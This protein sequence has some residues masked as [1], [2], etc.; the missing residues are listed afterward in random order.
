MDYKICNSCGEKVDINAN[1]CGNCKSTS[2]RSP[3]SVAPVAKTSQ[4]NLIYSL[5]YWPY[6]GGY[7]LSKSKLGG[8]LIFVIMF[9]TA[10]STPFVGGSILLAVIFAA[11]F[12][13]L[14]Y[15]IHKIKR[16]PSQVQVN[17]N[18]LGLLTDIKNLMFYW[19]NRNTGEF[20]LSKTKLIT[21][22]IY[23]LFFCVAISAV[24]ASLYV[25]FAVAAF[26]TAPAFLI[27][28]AVHKLTNNNPTN[29][30]PAKPKPEVKKMPKKAEVETRQAI[31]KSDVI[32]EFE[33][34]RVKLEELKSVYAKKDARARELIE[35]KF[36][37]P[38]ITYTRFIAIVDKSSKLFKIKSEEILNI[39][40]LASEDSPR[41]DSEIKSK[42]EILNSLIDKTDDLINELVLSMDSEDDDVDDLIVDMEDLI[43]SIKKY[44]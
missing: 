36:S 1:F 12:F 37:P 42:F 32:P 3:N 40:D 39:L 28:Y 30:K 8:V 10:F 6:E 17:N 27:G 31:E 14:S 43:G 41:I 38:Q 44:E 16:N 35:K 23:L 25:G 22:L 29:K 33:A 19:Q 21:A 5:F 24:S 15:I 11:I 20:V 34:Y 4:G 26:Y 2:F 13:L 18:D 9:L 7:V